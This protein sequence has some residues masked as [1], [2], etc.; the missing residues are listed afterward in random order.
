M[1]RNPIFRS[2]RRCLYR[3]KMSQSSKQH[4]RHQQH[5]QHRHRVLR[6]QCPRG[7]LRRVGRIILPTWDVNPNRSSVRT[8]SKICK[9]TSRVKSTPLRLCFA[10]SFFSCSGL[11]SGWY[12]G[13]KASS[14]SSALSIQSISHVSFLSYI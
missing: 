13:S 5:R 11:C 8:V 9:P 6:Q 2:P 12:V 3:R 14:F 10:L 1:K 4:P 7:R